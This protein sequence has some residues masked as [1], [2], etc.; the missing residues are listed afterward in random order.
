MDL[1]QS[2]HSAVSPDDAM[3][4]PKSVSVYLSE[5]RINQNQRLNTD[6]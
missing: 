3:E 4:N 1:R 2:A 5:I 6:H